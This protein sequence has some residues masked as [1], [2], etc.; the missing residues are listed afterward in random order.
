MLSLDVGQVVTAITA[1]HTNRE[2]LFRRDADADEPLRSVG[3]KLSHLSSEPTALA[4][5][6]LAHVA[7]WRRHWA[8]SGV[9]FGLRSDGQMSLA[10]RMWYGTVYMLTIT[11][12]VNC[13]SDTPLHVCT[14][15]SLANGKGNC[16]L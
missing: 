10:E 14:L 15:C 4:G 11:N 6:R 16:R 5:L 8:A 9:K 2:F 13:K 1:L 12:R 7:W 3:Q